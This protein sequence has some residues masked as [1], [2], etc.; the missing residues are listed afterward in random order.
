M[1]APSLQVHDLLEIDGRLLRAT[2]PSAP[3][4]LTACLGKSCHVIARR[5]ATAEHQ[6]PIGICG[7]QRNQRFAANIPR[8]LVRHV[9]TPPQVLRLVD[10][11]ASPHLPGLRSLVSLKKQWAG[12]ELPWGPIGSVALE[13][14]TG[15]SRVNAHSDLDIVLHAADRFAAVDAKI[16]FASTVSLPARV[17]IRVETPF[18]GFSLAEFA[19]ARAGRILLRTPEGPILGRDP[20]DPH[21]S[22]PVE[23]ARLTSL[24]S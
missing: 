8:R 16:L 3:A 20:W 13:L 24:R 19:W 22:S 21:L 12:L 6:V 7:E 4:W 23:A 17:D 15:S 5:F 11:L 18:C 10:G 9:L 1:N 2:L 14:V